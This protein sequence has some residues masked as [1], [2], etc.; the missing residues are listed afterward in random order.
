MGIKLEIGGKSYEVTDYGTSEDST[1]LSVGDSSGGIGSIDFSIR[2]VRNP[3]LLQGKDFRLTDSRR[4]STRGQI[5]SVEPV[6]GTDLTRISC[7]SR[8]DKLNVYNVQAQ[9]FRGT[10][11]EAFLYYLKLANVTTDIWV[12]E[13]IRSKPVVF[14]GWFGELW[15][16]FKNLAAA[17]NCEIAL[18]GDVI[19]MRKLRTRDAHR[20]RLIDSSVSFG[21]GSTALNVEVYRYDTRWT[22]NDLIYPPDRT[23]EG[24]SVISA[25]AGEETEYTL[26]L[27]ETASIATLKPLEYRMNIGKTAFGSTSMYS[28]CTDDGTQ[29]SEAAFLRNG[30]SIEAIINEDTTSV[31]IKFRAPTGLV[32]KD[33]E[34]VSTYTIGRGDGTTSN[35]YSTLRL[36]GSGAIYTK[37]LLRTPTGLTPAETSTEVGVTIDN[38]FITDAND[39]FNAASRLAASFRGESFGLRGTTTR[40]NPRYDDE[41]SKNYAKYSDVQAAYAGMTYAEVVTYITGAT[42]VNYAAGLVPIEP[43][44]WDI[45]PA[46]AGVFSV[47]QFEGTLGTK[48]S[49]IPAEQGEW[50]NRIG[51]RT[52]NYFQGTPGD[53]M[54][55]SMTYMVLDY[56]TNDSFSRIS[57]GGEVYP[58]ADAAAGPAPVNPVGWWVTSPE[59]NASYKKWTTVTVS[60]SLSTANPFFRPRISVFDGA[61]I[62]ISSVTVRNISKELRDATPLTYGDEFYTWD[63]KYQNE[64][65]LQVF[66]NANGARVWDEFSNR[67][68]RIRSA[69]VGTDTI[70]YDADNDL[71]YSDFNGLRSGKT[72]GVVKSAIGVGTYRDVE[73][74]G[75]YLG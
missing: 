27:S 16:N 3:F 11:E 35:R 72:Y 36:W 49:P 52:A 34:P 69:N 26:D 50:G 30:G 23:G 13:E 56:G 18:V 14:P 7:Y 74:E 20:G 42:P 25:G 55:V 58:S 45:F 32:N 59:Y 66:G 70:S 65:A 44:S 10:L 5:D 28:V 51:L 6:R 73:R 47:D 61:T 15:F 12:D 31:T 33:G 22:D 40:V 2:N 62:L 64:F 1:P 37:D 48:V 19:L 4:G 54:E 43:G 71:L 67:Y 21:G 24:L 39:Q 9:P 57:F 38:P 68:Y 41:S 63:S 53:T 75:L 29:L 46:G 17:H 60:P 8:L